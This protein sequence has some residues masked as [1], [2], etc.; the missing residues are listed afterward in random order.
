MWPYTFGIRTYG[1]I[2]VLGMV[3]YGL[4]MCLRAR[5]SGVTLR[6][7]IFLALAYPLGMV[8][9]AKMLYDTLGGHFADWAYLK[10]ATYECGL[11]GGPLAYLAVA[12]PAAL[13]LRGDR[14]AR[15]DLIALC[16]PPAMILAK[17][18]CFVNGCC[19]GAPC[20]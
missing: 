11:W 12:V 8:V 13:V 15:L 17:L 6:F 1:I 2:Y 5:R 7:A 3:V 19:Y 16:L 9:G 18:A 14:S 10:P 4:L 20:N